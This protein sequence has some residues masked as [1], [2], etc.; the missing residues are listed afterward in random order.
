MSALM[1]LLQQVRL[2]VTAMENVAARMVSFNDSENQDTDQQRGGRL[3]P[4]MP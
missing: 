3:I 1:R 2:R 4:K